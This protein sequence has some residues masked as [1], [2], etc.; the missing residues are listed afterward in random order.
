MVKTKQHSNNNVETGYV[1]TH[2]YNKVLETGVQQYRDL[3]KGSDG[4]SHSTSSLSW[5]EEESNNAWED[6]SDP[7]APLNYHLRRRKPASSSLGSLFKRNHHA[8]SR[9]SATGSP[10]HVPTRS[11]NDR[12]KSSPFH[13]NQET[14]QSSAA[15]TRGMECLKKGEYD[16]AVSEFSSAIKLSAHD[17]K[18]FVQRAKAYMKLKRYDPAIDDYTRVLDMTPPNAEILKSRAQAYEKVQRIEDAITDY[19]TILERLEPKHIDVRVMRGKLYMDT[20]RLNDALSDFGEVVA[21]DPRF[22]QGFRYRALVYSKLGHFDLAL[23]DQNRLVSL[24]QNC[25]RGLQVASLLQRATILENLATEL[26]QQESLEQGNQSMSY[27][28]LEGTF[29]IWKQNEPLSIM[30]QKHLR[31]ATAD[32]TAVLEVDKDCIQALRGRGKAYLLLRSYKDALIDYNHLLSLDQTDE[33][34]RLSRASVYLHLGESSKSLAELNAL[35]QDKPQSNQTSFRRAWVYITISE[36]TKALEDLNHLV[37]NGDLKSLYVRGQVYMALDRPQDALKDFEKIIENKPND[38]NAERSSRVA[39][40]MMESRQQQVVD[41]AYQWLLDQE[42]KE[43][44]EE[45]HKRS[46]KKT[47]K[48]KKKKKTTRDEACETVES[49]E[50][51]ELSVESQRRM[52]QRIL[53]RRL[54]SVMLPEA[55]N[56]GVS[57]REQE[58]PEE[59]PKKILVDEKYLRKRRKQLEKLREQLVT[60]SET[61]DLELLISTMGRVQRKHMHESLASE[62]KQAQLVIDRLEHDRNT[63]PKEE[64]ST[65]P[66]AP[67]A[68]IEEEEPEISSDTERSKLRALKRVH[69]QALEEKNAEIAMLRAQLRQAHVHSLASYQV[70]D[71]VETDAAMGKMVTFV[72]KSLRPTSSFAAFERLDQLIR[73]IGPTNESETQRNRIIAYIEHISEKPILATGSYPLKTYLPDGDI[74]ASLIAQDKDWHLHVVDALCRAA[75]DPSQHATG[76]VVRNVTF[77]NAE[78][79]VVQCTVNNVSIDLTANQM[80]AVAAVSLLNEMDKRVGRSHLFKRSLLLIKA[81]CKYE[82]PTYVERSILGAR[83]GALAT[84]ALNTMVMSLFNARWKDISHP[85]QALVLFL[86]IYATFDWRHNAVSLFGDISISTLQRHPD[87]ENQEFLLDPGFVE[88]LSGVQLESWP[89]TCVGIGL[90]QNPIHVKRIRPIGS[91]QIRHCNV[92]D[93]LNCINNVARSVTPRRLMDLKRAFSGGYRRLIEILCSMNSRVKEEFDTRV[94]TICKEMTTEM[95]LAQ[96]NGVELDEFFAHTWKTYGR[97]D[98][99]RPDLLLHPRQMWHGVHSSCTQ[100]DLLRSNTIP[101]F[102][103]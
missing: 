46:G 1:P 76:C 26:Q 91:L 60:G 23:E 74:D 99:W 84:Y 94:E 56:D 101:T 62:C 30:A 70:D 54:P 5:D 67:A 87:C 68:V 8:T 21:I 75:L 49:S 80:G 24:E 58:K 3:K 102:K 27:Q 7:A 35:L 83:D 13:I 25:H 2:R 71:I 48:K 19:T 10:L 78:V 86:H 72:A 100:T 20:G 50:S 39:K 6:T 11:L 64:D 88:S 93:P 79:K 40:E 57:P 47:K 9:Y 98:G 90:K 44:Q 63:A 96:I 52:Q 59:Q 29:S 55:S 37:E 77:I 45:Q 32:Y 51:V 81:W 61:L 92:V 16:R 66:P 22:E 95:L 82:S 41:Q 89:E 12:K 69:K 34:S 36:Y 73:W 103:F 97:G 18:S 33:D 43:K 31:T 65:V 42:E 4:S 85:L 28:I 14:Y 15:R 53:D 38:T 17:L